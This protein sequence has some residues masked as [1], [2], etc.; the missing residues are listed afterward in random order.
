MNYTADQII[1]IEDKFAAIDDMVERQIFDHHFDLAETHTTS[2][3]KQAKRQCPSCRGAWS[4]TETFW[5]HKY[6]NER[7]LMDYERDLASIGDVELEACLLVAQTYKIRAIKMIRALYP[8]I[9][10]NNAK[11]IIERCSLETVVTTTH[12]VVRG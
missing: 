2:T 1:E 8:G 10:L 6:R 9:G 5:D 11:L 12:T 7:A 3:F 4:S